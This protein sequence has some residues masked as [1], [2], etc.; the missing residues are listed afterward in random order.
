MAS[1]VE[2][3]FFPPPPPPPVLSSEP[4]GGGGWRGSRGNFPD[5]SIIHTIIRVECMVVGEELTF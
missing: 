2:P 4:V 1:S 3:F 5:L